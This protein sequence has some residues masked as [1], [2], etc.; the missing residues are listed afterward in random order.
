MDEPVLMFDGYWN[1]PDAFDGCSLHLVFD[2]ALMNGTKDKHYLPKEC[3]KQGAWC[4]SLTIQQSEFHPNA[5]CSWR[6]LLGI[7]HLDAIWCNVQRLLQPFGH[8]GFE[9][10][11]PR[12]HS[13]PEDSGHFQDRSDCRVVERW[14][15][16]TKEGSNVVVDV[17]GPNTVKAQ[18]VHQIAL[19]T[20]GPAREVE[21]PSLDVEAIPPMPAGDHF[22]CT[23]FHAEEMLVICQFQPLRCIA[24]VRP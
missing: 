17:N 8:L 23:N 9:L 18:T 3:V 5:L 7:Q 21:G 15:P 1:R 24:G 6:G 2:E 20:V 19:P 4:W 10:L 11:G 12:R 22:L 14:C 13:C 16:R